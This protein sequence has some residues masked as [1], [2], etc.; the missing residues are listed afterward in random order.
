MIKMNVEKKL[1]DVLIKCDFQ[2]D[3]NGITAVYGA[4]GA[5]KTSI[6]NMMAGLISPDSGVISFRDKEFF[7][8]EK[9][10]N[11]PAN[12][13]FIGYV[14]QDARLFPNMSVKDNLLY[15]SNRKSSYSLS[16]NLEQACSLLGITH[17]LERYPQKLSGGE[18]QRVAIGRALLS[19][20]E[21]LLMDE[22]LASLDSLRAKELISYINLIRN[23]Y[24]IPILYV[25]HSIDEIMQLADNAIYMEQGALKY[26]GNVV[27]VLNKTSHTNSE[28]SSFNTVFEGVI[29]EYDERTSNALI[30][31][32]AGIVESACENVEIGKKVRFSI[33]V[34]DVVLSI[35]YPKNISIRN[36]YKGIISNIIK[37]KNNFYDIEIKIGES[38]WA[39][40][41]SGAY[42]DLDIVCGKNVYVMFK[43]AAVTE[44]LK[45]VH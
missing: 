25:S 39:R 24:N 5:G 37:N 18:K 38:V 9:K 45:I 4:S 20:P 28:N 22:P 3:S 36:I 33:N 44:S 8:H 14:F 32:G 31:F 30:S 41:S 2:L 16:C 12:K 21:M 23:N 13:R 42:K 10:I 19:N 1:G 29:K 27:E 6:I 35:D 26:Y 7:N 15:G 17:L 11:L 43:S 40:I 34:D